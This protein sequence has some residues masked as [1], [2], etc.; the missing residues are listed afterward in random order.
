MFARFSP[1]DQARVPET[2][3]KQRDDFWSRLG[4]LRQALSPRERE[5]AAS[6]MISMTSAQQIAASWRLEAIRTLLWALNVMGEML[7]YDAPAGDAF[8]K[9]FKGDEF[10]QTL[11]TSRLRPTAEL[12]DARSTAELWHWR[13][14]TRQLI[15]QGKVF[16]QTPQTAKAGI[17]TF[18]DVVR[19]SAKLASERGTIPTQID[20]DFPLLGKA[21]RDA[22]AQE[23]AQ[24]NSIAME[25]HFALNWLCG[26]APGGRWDE[27]P[28][29]T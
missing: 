2:A 6:T 25:R 12:E 18:D 27:T 15:E 3:A 4:P 11:A 17:R 29:D 5:F 26:Y 23:F 24:A 14:R 7:P 13:A 19:I 28:T 9:K 20:G 1:E 22:S 8:L 10:D 21:Y 16:P